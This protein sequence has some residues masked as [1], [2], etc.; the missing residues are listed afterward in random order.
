MMGA[1]LDVVHRKLSE[2]IPVEKLS[3]LS[4]ALV[5]LILTSKNEDKMPSESAKALLHHWQ[6]NTL[7][8][9]TGVTALLQ[10]AIMLEPE[11]VV[12]AFDELQMA[13]ALKQIKELF[14]FESVK[15]E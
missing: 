2:I 4:E 5:D 11:K 10:V 15:Q 1:K 6:D 9:E 8:D 12:M 3:L 14:E 13:D 7:S